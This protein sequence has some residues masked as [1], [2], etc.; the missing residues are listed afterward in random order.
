MHVYTKMYG[1]PIS[2][3]VFFIIGSLIDIVREL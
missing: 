3:I 1:D 2:V